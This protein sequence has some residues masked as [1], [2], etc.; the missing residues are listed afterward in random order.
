MSKNTRVP[1]RDVESITFCIDRIKID[2]GQNKDPEQIIVQRTPYKNTKA[3]VSQIALVKFPPVVIPISSAPTNATHS[4]DV[5]LGQLVSAD[6]IATALANGA[7]A[8]RLNVKKHVCAVS[9][10]NNETSGSYDLTVVGSQIASGKYHY[11]LENVNRPMS[12]SGTNGANMF[13][14]STM[15]MTQPIGTVIYTVIYDFNQVRAIASNVQAD[16]TL[17]ASVEAEVVFSYAQINVNVEK[18]VDP[19]SGKQAPRRLL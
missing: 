2:E 10:L 7:Y 17:D 9:N 1:A 15:P 18:E 5:T 13:E 12:A 8:M 3:D 16:L 4:A 14:T 6:T 19:K 11:S